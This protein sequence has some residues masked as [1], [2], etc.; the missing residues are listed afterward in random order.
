M[1]AA[2]YSLEDTIRIAGSFAHIIMSSNAGDLRPSMWWANG[3]NDADKGKLP[4]KAE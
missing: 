2:R 3:W 4:K 1:R